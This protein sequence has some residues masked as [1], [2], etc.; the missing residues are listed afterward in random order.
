MNLGDYVRIVVRRGWLMLLLAV[1]A[2]GS[3]YYL[4]TRQAPIWRA[5]QVVLLQ[6]SRIDL[7]LTEASKS[8]IENNIAYIDSSL[9]AQQV[10]ERL[11]LDMQPQ[12]LM[13]NATIVSNRNNLTVRIE[14]DSYAPEVAGDIAREWGNLL[15][16]YRNEQNQIARREDRMNAMLQDVPTI[17]LQRPRPKINAA[18]GGV[19]GLILGAAVVLVLEF[20]ESSVV[21]SREDVERT[22]D[23][24]VL[25]SIPD[26]G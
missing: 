24:N 1:L 9:R 6:P 17:A 21:R 22:L 2:S 7:G 15:I 18:A 23:L 16:E 12:D 8:A 4:S 3:A 10:I 19:L 11:N 13:G 5:T 20:I 25:A 26:K 14:V